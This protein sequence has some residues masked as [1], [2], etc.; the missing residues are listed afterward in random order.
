[1][2]ASLIERKFVGVACLVAVELGGCSWVCGS[3]LPVV[4]GS[5]LSLPLSVAGGSP[6]C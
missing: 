1:V 4:C 2:V 5:W 6:L 3:P